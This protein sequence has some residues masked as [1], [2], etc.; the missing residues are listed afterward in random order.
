LRV[1]DSEEEP[2]PESPSD[3]SESLFVVYSVARYN[4]VLA[5]YRE[6]REDLAPE[7]RERALLWSWFLRKPDLLLGWSRV[8][9]SARIERPMKWEAEFG[10]G[11]QLH[12][13]QLQRDVL[14][15]KVLTPKT[16]RA[17]VRIGEAARD[18][19]YRLAANKHALAEARALVEVRAT[20]TT[21]KRNVQR[22]IETYPGIR[23]ELEHVLKA[24]GAAEVGRIGRR[25]DAFLPRQARYRLPGGSG[26]R[27]AAGV[28]MARE[29]LRKLGLTGSRI[30][31]LLWAWSLVPIPKDERMPMKT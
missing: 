18:E 19:A 22:L 28:S 25:F 17:I 3:Q 23:A 11:Q 13:E 1:G 9:D 27:R 31:N 15:A 7:D 29:Q 26:R 14:Q 16:R 6:W 21:I 12:R 10:D 2:V 8:S 20:I 5:A 4:V 30:Q 24:L